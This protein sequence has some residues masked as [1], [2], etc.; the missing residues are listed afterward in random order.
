MDDL[1]AL[2]GS[3]DDLVLLRTV[4]P[5]T[6]NC[7]SAGQAREK[8]GGAGW[9]IVGLGTSSDFKRETQNDW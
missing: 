1:R 4:N 3:Y 6:G 8:G 9:S 2:K 5:R 7:V